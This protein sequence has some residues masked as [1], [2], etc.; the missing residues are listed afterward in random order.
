MIVETLPEKSSEILNAGGVAP[1]LPQP[2]SVTE[3]LCP[4]RSLM[5]LW[6]CFNNQPEAPGPVVWVRERTTWI[7]PL[8]AVCLKKGGGAVAEGETIFHR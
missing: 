4:P 5:T 8:L 2:L 3:V 7:S 1:F 6:L